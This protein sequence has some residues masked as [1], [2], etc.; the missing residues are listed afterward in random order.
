MT[1]MQLIQP[2]GQVSSSRA[3]LFCGSLDE[4]LINVL[5]IDH[6]R[7][8]NVLSH[9]R[10][11]KKAGDNPSKDHSLF[12]RLLK[13]LTKCVECWQEGQKKL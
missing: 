6:D 7:G 8:I 2:Q 13:K 11:A 10:L 5:V 3:Q 12:M 4:E 1:H 9:V